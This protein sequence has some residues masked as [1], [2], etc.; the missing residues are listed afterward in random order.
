MCL[1]GSL[2]PPPA[3]PLQALRRGQRPPHT[4]DART[5]TLHGVTPVRRGCARV[6]RECPSP[7]LRPAILSPNRGVADYGFAFRSP[8]DTHLP[9]P[10][11]S[12]ARIAAGHPNYGQLSCLCV[13]Q[14]C[15]C[16]T[17]NTKKKDS[18]IH[19]HPDHP[20]RTR[21]RASLRRPPPPREDQQKQP[22]KE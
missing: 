14:P 11:L 18:R 1:A 5:H 20:Y 7:P 12:L 13:P 9:L 22:K 21:R 6:C 19:T 8:Q 15:A 3:V 2:H 16:E 4:V 17:N 10:F